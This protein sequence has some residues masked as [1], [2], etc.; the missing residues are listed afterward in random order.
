MGPSFARA[1]GAKALYLF[2]TK[3]LA[4]DQVSELLELN[5]AGELGIKAITFDGDTPG[6]ARQAITVLENAITSASGISC[7][8][9]VSLTDVW[10]IEVS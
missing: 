9:M 3:A 6:D 2:P 5:A 10:E 8:S 7:I 1:S 4:Q